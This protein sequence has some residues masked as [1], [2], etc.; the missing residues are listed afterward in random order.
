MSSAYY[1]ILFII[2]DKC[3]RAYST[4]TGEWIRDMEG[5]TERLIGHQCD[6]LN[7]K[8]L[9]AC[10]EIGEIIAWK[11]KSGVIHSRVKLNFVQNNAVVSNFTLIEMKDKRSYGLV[12]WRDGGGVSK[13][14]IGIYDLSDGTL[15]EVKI[16]LRLRYVLCMHC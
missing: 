6:P 4:L 13:I 9:Y 16:P 14:K 15:Q 8:L 3:I 10:T 5:S 12:A 2:W 7:P 1:R 11:W